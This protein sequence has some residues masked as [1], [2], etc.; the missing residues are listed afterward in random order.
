MYSNFNKWIFTLTLHLFISISIF[1]HLNTHSFEQN[2]IRLAYYKDSTPLSYI[3]KN[4]VKGI[5]LILL[6]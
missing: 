2:T 4:A 3:K 1:H 6:T 5:F